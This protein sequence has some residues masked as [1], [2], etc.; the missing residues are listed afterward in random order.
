MNILRAFFIIVWGV[1][2]FLISFSVLRIITKASYHDFSGN[3]TIIYVT[4]GIIYV[5]TTI[6]LSILYSKKYLYFL[7]LLSILCIVS[8]FLLIYLL[9]NFKM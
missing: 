8:P 4:I 9:N 2:A 5:I 3:G 1:L 7:A 6:I